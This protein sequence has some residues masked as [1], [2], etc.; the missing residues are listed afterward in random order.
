MAYNIPQD[1]QTLS[2]VLFFQ[3]EEKC[4]I[5]EPGEMVFPAAEISWPR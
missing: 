1:P 5:A 3:G 4:W 2:V